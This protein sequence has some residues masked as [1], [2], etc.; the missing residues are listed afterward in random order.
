[1]KRIDMKQVR[2]MRELNMMRQKLEYQTKLY[3]KEIA[4]SSSD[5]VENLMDKA[6]DVLFDVGFRIFYKLIRSRRNKR[7]KSDKDEDH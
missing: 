6:K 7:K 1:M 2:N 5:V 3:E 4:D